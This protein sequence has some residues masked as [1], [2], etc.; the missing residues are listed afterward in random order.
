MCGMADVGAGV[1][2]KNVEPA[3]TFERCGEESAN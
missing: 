2:D 1:V 3:A